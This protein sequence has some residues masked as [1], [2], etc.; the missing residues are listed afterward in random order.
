MTQHDIHYYHRSQVPPECLTVHN[1]SGPYHEDGKQCAMSLNMICSDRGDALTWHVCPSCQ[2]QILEQSQHLSAC[3]AGQTAQH[4][5]A[6]LYSMLQYSP[7][8]CGLAAPAAWQ[9]EADSPAAQAVLELARCERLLGP[10]NDSKQQS[11]APAK[12]SPSMQ[13]VQASVLEPWPLY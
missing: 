3:P 4:T 11:A 1:R 8:P 9:P 2:C 6:W 7:L 13:A 10:Q 12:H 5:I